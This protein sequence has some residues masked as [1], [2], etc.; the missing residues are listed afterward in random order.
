MN[1]LCIGVLLLGLCAC[2]TPAPKPTPRTCEAVPIKGTKADF[3][4]AKQMLDD[5]K[6]GDVILC[7]KDASSYIK[8]E[9][10]EGKHTLVMGRM[11]DGSLH[12][13]ERP[14]GDLPPTQIQI[15]AVFE[16]LVKRANDKGIQVL[17]GGLGS[18]G[19]I[20]GDIDA[21]RMSIVIS[22]WKQA[23]SAARLVA[24]ELRQWDIKGH[25][26]VSIMQRTCNVLL[27]R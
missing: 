12:R 16:S 14:T 26:G 13:T 22:D 6:I 9:R 24:D 1:R 27:R 23:D 19:Q 7:S 8:V 11:P 25:L 10:L 3:T 21:W 17:S 5:V 2:S 20:E 15:D 4:L 18:C